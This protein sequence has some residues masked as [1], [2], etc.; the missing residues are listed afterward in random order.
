M[1]M[2]D[3]WSKKRYQLHIQEKLQDEIWDNYIQKFIQEKLE[4]EILG[5]LHTFASFAIL[6]ECS[7]RQ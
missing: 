2:T 5:H 1:M 6:F 4:D 7:L 3:G